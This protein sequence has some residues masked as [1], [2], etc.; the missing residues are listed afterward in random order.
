MRL[1]GTKIYLNTG[2]NKHLADIIVKELNL[3]YEEDKDIPLYY[4]KMSYILAEKKIEEML[5]ELEK[6]KNRDKMDKNTILQIERIINRRE[7]ERKREKFKDMIIY[8][9][10]EDYTEEDVRKKLEEDDKILTILEEIYRKQESILHPK[11]C[12]FIS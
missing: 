9:G 7:R 2:F 5:S 12:K 3:M 6:I 11:W 8:L 10:E 4:E 1:R